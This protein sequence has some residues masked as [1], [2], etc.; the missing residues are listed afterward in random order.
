MWNRLICVHN[1]E[2]KCLHYSTKTENLTFECI[3]AKS[4][5]EKAFS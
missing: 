3:P 5:Q 1:R 4:E 2:E